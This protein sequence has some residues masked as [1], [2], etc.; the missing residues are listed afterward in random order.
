MLLALARRT[1]GVGHH[2][3]QLRALNNDYELALRGTKALEQILLRSFKPQPRWRR[4]QAAVRDHSSNRRRVLEGVREEGLSDV[5][6]QN[7]A[8]HALTAQARL[9]CGGLLPK[10]IQKRLRE[11]R[12]ARNALAHD[13]DV[14]SLADRDAFLRAFSDVERFQAQVELSP[15]Y[16]FVR[17]VRPAVEKVEELR[18]NGRAWLTEMRKTARQHGLNAA[19]MLKEFIPDRTLQRVCGIPVTMLRTSKRVATMT[20]ANNKIS[21]ARARELSR[22]A[23]ERARAERDGEKT[24]LDT[25]HGREIR[26]EIG[27]LNRAVFDLKKKHKCQPSESLDEQLARVR[28]ELV[29]LYGRELEYELGT[30]LSAAVRAFI[31]GDDARLELPSS[32]SGHANN[33]VAGAY[34]KGRGLTC[35]YV[36]RG[37][38]RHLVLIRSESQRENGRASDDGDLHS[39]ERAPSGEDVR[40]FL[41]AGTYASRKMFN[42]ERIR[43]G[44]DTARPAG[45]RRRRRRKTPPPLEFDLG[46]VVDLKGSPPCVAPPR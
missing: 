46:A 40:S 16:C 29:N 9:P 37:T 11:M 32:L 28:R 6:V 25:N 35:V 36:G 42:F 8:L 21:R 7:V 33:V 45:S 19:R 31:E 17:V 26:K 4:F 18:S 41:G 14:D 23:H 10:H 3:A 12:A 15:W 24:A 1:R 43:S 2:S 13:F 38:A 5:R 22:E 39:G 34:A 44:N 20:M 27:S 30:Q